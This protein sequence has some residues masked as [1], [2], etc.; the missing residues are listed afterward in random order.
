MTNQALAYRGFGQPEEVLHLET[1]EKGELAADAIRV[2]MRYAPVNAS[3]L[4]PMT[5]AYQHR[6]TLPQVAGYEGMGVVTDAP[7][8][9]RHLMGRRVLALRGEGTWQSQVDIPAALAIS[10]P[11][12]IDD[13]LAARGYI[14]PLAAKLMLEYFSPAGKDIL[15]TAAGS[16][17]AMLLGQW[18]LRAGA[19]SV[20]GIH[21]SPVHAL[22]L[23]Q[24]GI[25]PVQEQESE[26]IGYY[27]ARAG[28]VYDATGGRL[29]ETLLEL[30]PLTSLFI[31][32]GLLSGEVFRAKH[33]LPKIHWFHVRHYLAAAGT[34]GWQQMFRALWP[35][36]AE[37][38]THDVQIFAVEEW[39]AAIGAYRTAGRSAK[40]LIK[41]DP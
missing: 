14:N 13:R 38:H 12:N 23:E 11:D 30:M 25:T 18:A 20:T 41:L 3:D 27:A 2:T 32:Y 16:E 35:L 19:R 5:G 31:S 22:K 17:C 34:D 36:L 1:G 6:I 24:C 33:H 28:V 10:V 29:A 37:T 40:P 15:L 26:A 9:Y 21:R 8:A 4:I 7:A 39:K